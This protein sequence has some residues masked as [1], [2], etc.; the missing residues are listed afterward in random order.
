M[1]LELN[2]R[3]CFVALETQVN[4]V[5]DGFFAANKLL[6]VVDEDSDEFGV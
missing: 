4:V 1:V 5:I 3:Y 2:I 6:I